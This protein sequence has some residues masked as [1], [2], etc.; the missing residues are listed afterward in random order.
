MNKFL[1]AGAVAL[2]MTAGVAMAQ[3]STSQTTTTVTPAPP[4]LAP[5]MPAVV[6]PPDGTLSVTRTQKSLSSDG[7][8]VDSNETTYRNT[9]GVADDSMTK[10]TTYPAPTATTTTTNKTTSNSVT[11]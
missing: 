5:A 1:A 9:A 3:T 8:R 11:Q 4:L 10:T 2:V 6:A 7:T